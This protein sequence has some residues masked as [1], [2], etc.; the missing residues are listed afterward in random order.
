MSVFEPAVN[1]RRG[2]LIKV[3]GV[4]GGGSNAVNH[5]FRHG[6]EGVDF[7]ICNTDLQA[8]HSSPIPNR[9][10]LGA[11]L[12]EGLGAGSM[13]D[14]GEKAA[15][16][17]M[18]QIRQ[19]M[20][21]NTK[22]IFI[23]A[24]MGGGTGTGAAPVIAKIAKELN[25][26]T[27]GI[28]TLP[29]ED[30]GPQRIGQANEG[31]EKLRPHVDALLTIC[32]D[33]IVDMYGDL[34][35][36]QA[37]SKADDILC[38]AAKGIAEII[39]KPGQINVDFMDVQTAMRDSGRAIMGTGFATGENRAENAVRMAL[40]SPLLDNTRIRGAQ[41]LLVNF[42][43]GHK[44][45]V[46][47]E[48]SKVKKFLQEEAGHTAHLKMGITKDESLGEEIAIT[49]I[50]TGFEVRL[51]MESNVPQAETAPQPVIAHNPYSQ[52]PPASNN[53]MG[54]QGN[55]SPY[56]HNANPYGVN[57]NTANKVVQPNLFN[58]PPSQPTVINHVPTAFGQD[59]HEDLGK[60]VHQNSDWDQ[61]EALNPINVSPKPFEPSSDEWNEDPMA[62]IFRDTRMENGRKDRESL[63]DNDIETPAYMRRGINLEAAPPSQSQ[64]VS[65]ITIG[66][67][68]P[69]NARDLTVKPNRH[70]HDNVD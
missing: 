46:M 20:E 37:F 8:L 24:G 55:N 35:I 40:D 28:V 57:P 25:I 31:L 38:T 64:L 15:M 44:E 30:E 3:I 62:Q 39:T 6:I 11:Q 60:T 17:N 27:V 23:T 50:A 65:K 70:L 66:E 2:N 36:T 53:G 14:M 41:H 16:E 42:A 34:T 47:S 13:P 10:Q 59:A 54:N 63:L 9:L 48:I 19:I 18:Q 22:M 52:N 4:G 43:Y 32:N 68:D 5:M 29:F 26:L 21:D 12:T 51:Q 69:M 1:T 45:P 56:G 49:V 58:T 61:T 7:Y 33:R 67:E